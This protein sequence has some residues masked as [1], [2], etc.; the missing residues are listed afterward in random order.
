[1]GASGV[2]EEVVGVSDDGEVTE[3]SGASD[4]LAD[5]IAVAL[6][7]EN[8]PDGT[9]SREYLRKRMRLLDLEIKHFDEDY[10]LRRLGERLRIGIQILLIVGGAVVVLALGALVWSA[11]HSQSV[12]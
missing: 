5:G 2:D 12:V 6:M 11:A 3:A 8:G 9:L 1:M 4:S 10:I 7:A